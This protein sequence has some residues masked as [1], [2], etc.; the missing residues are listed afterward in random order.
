LFFS[1]NYLE[2]CCSLLLPKSRD[3]PFLCRPLL[4]CDFRPC[5][6][7]RISPFF[8]VRSTR[9]GFGGLAVI[10][11]HFSNDLPPLFPLPFPVLL[12]IGSSQNDLL[13]SNHHALFVRR[14]PPRPRGL[15]RDEV[16]KTSLISLLLPTLVTVDHPWSAFS[17]FHPCRL[18]NRSTNPCFVRHH[19]DVFIPEF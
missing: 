7:A 12:T 14:K 11:D 16:F 17:S 6:T 2:F 19:V 18:P 9:T 4:V 5:L 3:L 15:A 8:L 10:G 13:Y 1:T